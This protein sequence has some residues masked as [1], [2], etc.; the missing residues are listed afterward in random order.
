MRPIIRQATIEEVK[1]AEKF[2]NEDYSEFKSFAEES[3]ARVKNM[4]DMG[5]RLIPREDKPLILLPQGQIIDW[6]LNPRSLDILMNTKYTPDSP[7]TGA[8]V[9]FGLVYFKYLRR[10]QIKTP[11]S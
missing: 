10:H 5:Y 2:A 1:S 9:Y 11:I 6:N 8:A 7:V 4:E 3:R